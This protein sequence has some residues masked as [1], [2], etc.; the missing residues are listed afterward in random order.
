MELVIIYLLI[1]VLQTAKFLVTR[2]RIEVNALSANGFTALD[3]LAQ[4]HRDIK[5]FD[6]S[7]C[8]GNV[9][10]LRTAQLFPRG[11]WTPN[12]H[13][14]VGPAAAAAAEENSATKERMIKPKAEGWLVRK[15]DS[16][17]VVASLIATM[18]FQSGLSPPGG[19]WQDDFQGNN[20]TGMRPHTAGKS[21]MAAKSSDDYGI[22]LCSNSIGFVA[23]LS[24][25]LLLI[26]GLPFKQRF[27]MWVLTVI[28]WVTII[29]MALT[30]RVSILHFTPPDQ[31]EVATKVVNY[32][33]LA[34]CGVMALIFLLHSIRLGPK[35][36]P[37]VGLFCWQIEPAH[38]R[39][40]PPRF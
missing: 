23:S 12:D 2:T 18:A 33:V 39:I 38:H 13:G 5:D 11:Q 32:G 17:M 36:G 34:W 28:V 10:A 1:A 26:T 24:I 21:I 40:L 29:S 30:Y 3:I 31:L 8:L 4:S 27:F 7:E 14:H 6:I 15:R 16:M 22:Y 19:L 35:F 9:G 25:I 20:A 37:L